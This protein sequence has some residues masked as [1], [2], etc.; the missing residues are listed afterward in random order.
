M[1]AWKTKW[2]YLSLAWL[3]PLP[4]TKHSENLMANPANSLPR[5]TA[6][7]Q[8]SPSSLGKHSSSVDEEQP[9]AKK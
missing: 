4:K 8:A 5:D 3:T 6:L 7:D 2:A 1:T 9:P